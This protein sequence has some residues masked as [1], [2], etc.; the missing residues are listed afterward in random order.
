MSM[1]LDGNGSRLPSAGRAGSKARVGAPTR[2]WD[3]FFV[4]PGRDNAEVESVVH[5]CRKCKQC[6]WSPAD[7]PLCSP[8][9]RGS[10]RGQPHRLRLPRPRGPLREPSPV[11][12]SVRCRSRAARVAAAS[13]CALRWW[14]QGKPEAAESAPRPIVGSRY[15]CKRR[16]RRV[17]RCRVV[18]RR[19]RT[20]SGTGSIRVR[21]RRGVPI[22]ARQALITP[23]SGDRMIR[24]CVS[25]RP[26]KGPGV[27]VG[28]RRV[29]EGGLGTRRG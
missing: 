16:K 9:L 21:G 6:T 15:F 24:V 28:R 8:S 23:G 7:L 4:V 3:E 22:S 12:A 11:P 10:D 19:G 5:P 26:F 20:W 25:A 13:A 18:A 1:F 29:R 27:F 17:L 2:R 14:L